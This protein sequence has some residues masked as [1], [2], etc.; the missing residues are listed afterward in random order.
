MIPISGTI[1]TYLTSIKTAIVQ[2]LSTI[3]QYVSG[4]LDLLK[5]ILQQAS[6]LTDKGISMIEFL[7]SS[8]MGLFDPSPNGNVYKYGVVWINGIKVF[9]ETL[10]KILDEV[11][12]KLFGTPLKIIEGF[13]DFVLKFLPL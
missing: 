4:H 7:V 8:S 12:V 9:L 6:H 3:N 13:F 1:R 2:A 5:M 10:I 11:P